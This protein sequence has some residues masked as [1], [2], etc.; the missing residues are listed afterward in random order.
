MI[1][2]RDGAD[3]LLAVR[4]LTKHFGGV[5][6]LTGVDLAV[7]AGEVHALIG[8]NGSGKS[9]LIKCLAGYHQ[10]DGGTVRLHGR[11]VAYPMVSRE[12]AAAGLAFLHQDAPVAPNMTVLENIRVGRYEQRLLGKVSPR[13]ERQRVRDLL[14]SVGLDVDPDLLASRLPA[15]ERS[16]LGFAAAVA[17]LPERGGVLVL[18]EPTSSL[19]PGAAARL[20]EGVRAVTANG[21]AVLL[22][23]HRLDE[24]LAESD[25]VSVLRDGRHVGTV[26]TAQSNQAELIH[27]MLG[28]ELADIYPD[29]D[30]HPR[31]D[32]LEVKGLS[33]R[34]VRDLDLHVRA[35]EIVGVTGLVGMGQD[36]LPYLLY[37]ALPLDAGS[38]RLGGGELTRVRPAA[39]RSRGVALVPADRANASGAM[40]ASLTENL[41]LPVLGSLM[42]RGRLDHRAE[43]SLAVRTIG[44]YDVRPSRAEAP[45][46]AL[47][48]GNQQK[49][50][51]A[52]WLQT[53]PRLL[54]LHEPTLGV[55]IAS[56]AN[57]F[58]IVRAAADRG[59]AVLIASSEYEDLANVCD[60]VVVLN[61][62]RVVG[63]LTGSQ[64]TEEAI[65]QG[66]FA[67][68]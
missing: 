40:T 32:V 13:R 11:P 42:R 56:R 17:S 27:L 2:D 15:A 25:R 24:I 7:R 66:C 36:E 59:A 39:M 68:A 22:V 26:Q 65:L 49:L 52:K 55:D 62:G 46:R 58:S 34:I 47:S 37:G 1:P 5:A 61:R 30:P 4:G 21:S 60:R 64:L 35:G 63:E 16:L 50:L 28:R 18:D 12:L 51:L 3:E 45:L 14:R 10:P 57:I 43:R 33:G 54:M 6:A 31:A 44:D 9:T 29:K 67:A 41:S 38:V 53:D 48:G 23:S 19:P 8:Q 20:Y